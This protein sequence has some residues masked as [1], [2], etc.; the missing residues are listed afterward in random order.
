MRRISVLIAMFSISAMLH[1]AEI[2]DYVGLVYPP[3]PAGFVEK[4]G[5]LVREDSSEG[6]WYA[7]VEL[8]GK[9]M[10]WLERQ[11]GRI[12]ETPKDSRP[13][14]RP[15]WKVEDALV[16]PAVR[17][18]ETLHQGMDIECFFKGNPDTSI[19]AIG[20]WSWRQKQVGG[21]ARDIRVA[22][23]LHPTLPK[24]ESIPPQDVRC[25][26]NEDRD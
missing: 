19:I 18:G 23:R 9:S 10:I 14:N 4:G 13:T 26:L 15:I 21:Y 22:W 2:R 8:N 16:L 20:K 11:V 7:F 24:F 17:Q 12:V 3:S 25:E 5:G 6:L 1:A